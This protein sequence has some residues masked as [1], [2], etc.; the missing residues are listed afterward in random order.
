MCRAMVVV[1]L[2][3]VLATGNAF[4]FLH[5]IGCVLMR[6]VMMQMMAGMSGHDRK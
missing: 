4:A 5:V 1:A 3:V 6:V 2:L